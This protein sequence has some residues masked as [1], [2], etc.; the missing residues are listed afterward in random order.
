MTDLLPE[1]GAGHPSDAVALELGVGQQA[2]RDPSASPRA[3][4]AAL[5]GAMTLAEK[6]AQLGSTWVFQLLDGEAFD[7][8]RAKVILAEGIGHITRISGAANVD[9]R[10]AALLAN[11]I[12]RHLLER[13]RL[14]IPAIVHEETL[15]GLMAAGAVCHP[16]AI[17]VAASWRPDLAEAMA[18]HIGRS[19]RVR[20]AH[21]AL[22][23]IFDITRDPRWGRIEETY[24]ED[25]Y[26]A[27][28]M[29]VASV[30]G[31]Q[32]EGI[33]ATGKHLVGHGLPE[34]G[35]NR[36]PAH[37]GSREM[38]DMFLLP[39]EAA[40]RDAGLRSMMHAYE[41]VDGVP[42]V[43]SRELLTTIL[44]EEWGFEGVVVSDY[45][46]VEQLVDAHE[47]VADLS[48][49]AGLALTAG[50][51]VELPGTAAY[52]APLAAAIADGRVDLET[53]DTAVERVLRMKLELGL[54]EAPYVDP[55]GAVLP[56]EPERATARQL[57]AASLVL[58][59]NDGVLPLPPDLTRVAVIGPNADD[60]R[61]LLG[62]YAHLVHIQTL[63]EMRDLTNTF[64]F[65]VPDALAAADELA[66]LRTIRQALAARLGDDVQLVHERGCGVLDGDDAGIAAAAVA[67]RDA[68][69]AIVV[70]G[71]R[72]G[73]TDDA[74]VGEARDRMD[75]GLPGRQG[76]L[77]DAVLGTGTPVVLVLLSGRPLAIPDAA[78]RCAAVLMAWVPGDEGADA[79]VAALVGDTNPGGKL[80]V[81]VP[82]HVGQVP[83]FYNHKPSG[84]R[85]AWKNDYVDGPSKPLWPFGFGRSYTTFVLSG[86]SVTPEE[87]TSNGEVTVDLTVTNTGQ[88]AGDEVVQL[89]LR[90]PE[91]SVT[92]PVLELKGFARVHL[93]PGERCHISFGVSV[94]Q[95]AFTGLD[96]TRCVEPGVV[97]VLV[98]TSSVDLPLRGQV[99]V[100]GGRTP[101]P[102]PDRYLTHVRV[103]SADT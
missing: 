81:T 66:G 90:D 57:A 3:R 46:A 31:L 53:V 29:G 42:C 45:N 19:M 77:L 36:A 103:G 16:Q 11:A 61:A 79:V 68:E 51:D 60:P 41:D 50:T 96:H 100:T 59:E 22:S 23:P 84:G 20:G 33:A 5:L 30:R 99:V 35:M 32:G 7:P 71:E 69:L 13:T 102:T 64:A 58:L 8:I 56:D 92:R 91:A 83:T 48:T 14:G 55:D 47:L 62:D 89:Y 49:A 21:Q 17:G 85:S 75:V 15:H 65:P 52:G 72:S 74:T 70:L 27:M 44:R 39:F 40:V 54:F 6:L 12:Q 4:A 97:E 10:G 2:W 63:L 88:R 94:H 98:G 80:P 26:V 76:E 95:L 73:L 93:A 78:A 9:A 28:A 43:A 101:V 37:I 67:A 18:R 82:R 38:R 1:P 87:V 34:G 25:P 86:M 24:G